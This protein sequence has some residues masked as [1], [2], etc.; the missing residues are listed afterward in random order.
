MAENT[1]QF[2]NILGRL[3]PFNGKTSLK[4]FL[5]QFNIR[6]R[7]ENWSEEN[8][9]NILRCLCIDSAQTY[10][11][12]H[13]DVD[14]LDFNE[15]VSFLEKRFKV[16]ISK[17]EAYSQFTNLKQGLLNVKDYANKIDE[18]SE[19]VI[20]VLTEFENEES[21]DQFLISVFI[22][23]LNYE[24]KKLIGIHEFNSYN[25]CVQTALKAEKL[26]PNRK[27]INNL[28]KIDT[29]HYNNFIR[30]FNCGQRGHKR[31]NC[32]KLYQNYNKHSKN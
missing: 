32:P 27:M 23:G 19:S 8:K 14:N 17:H 12:S 6:A 29:P 2:S 26:V 11:N 1:I 25:N 21:R 22:N 15:L 9:V 16:V 5:N 28:N 10:L 20:D 7:L 30:C 4:S 18:I 3:K 13:P 24:I 31:I